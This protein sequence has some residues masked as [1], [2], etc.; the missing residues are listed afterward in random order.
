MK[1]EGFGIR[2]WSLIRKRVLELVGFAFVDDTDLVHTSSD[3][4]LSTEDLIEEAQQALNTWH[5]LIRA[6]GGDLAPE[7]GYWYLVELHWKNGKW[8]YRTIADCPGNL[9]IPGCPEPIRRLEVTESEE[10]LGI[11]SCPAG[12]QEAEVRYLQ[13]K[14]ALW[15]DHVRTK[16]IKKEEAWYCLNSTILKT[17]EYPLTATTLSRKEVDEIMRPLLRAFLNSIGIQKRLP[18]KLVYGTLKSRGLGIKDIYWLQLILHLHV[19]LRQQARDTPTSMLMTENE[20]LVQLYVGSETNFWELP[21]EQY[22]VLAPDGWMKH[23]WEA[24]SQTPLT[25]RGPSLAPPLQRQH[26][27]YIMDAFV[28][29]NLPLDILCQLNEVRLHLQ[30]VTLADLCTANGTA[31]DAQVWDGKFPSSRRSRGT[32]WIKTRSPTPHVLQVWRNALR[33][34]FLPPNT[35]S[36][37]LRS[38]L[39]PWNSSN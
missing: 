36:H 21:F 9:W 34:T 38:P 37:V 22:G 24:L 12:L 6:T 8:Q 32:A 4:D 39:G 29:Q 31:L 11:Q 1:A 19:L 3:P 18:R 13:G 25:L 33:Q 10:A 15:V 5:G 27:L 14:T 20:D 30:A 2:D 35:T 7:K 26:D 23:T 17:L 28:D 16:K